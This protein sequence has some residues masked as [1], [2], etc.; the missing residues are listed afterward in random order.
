MVCGIAPQSHYPTVPLGWPLFARLDL[1][2]PTFVRS[3]APLQRASVGFPD[4]YPVIVL[5]KTLPI[6]KDPV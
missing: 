1:H 4:R 2:L 3:Q 5:D 6:L